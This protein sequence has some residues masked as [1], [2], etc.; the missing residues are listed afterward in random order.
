VLARLRRNRY[1]ADLLG[2]A[3][4]GWHQIASAAATGDSGNMRVTRRYIR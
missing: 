3:S 1:F 4:N 2:D